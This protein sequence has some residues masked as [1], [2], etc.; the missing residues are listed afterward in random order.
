MQDLTQNRRVRQRRGGLTAGVRGRLASFTLVELLVS[1]TIML[2]LAAIT[3]RLVNTSLDSDRMKTGSRELQSYLAGAR[4]RAI[5]AGQPRGVRFKS[6]ENDPYS[7]RSFVYIGAPTNFSDGQP[8][9]VSTGITAIGP[10]L[11]TIQT[12]YGLANRGVLIPGAQVT[13]GGS[14]VQGGVYYSIAPNS[15]ISTALPWAANSPYTVGQTVQPTAANG[16]TY[17]CTAVTGVAPYNSGATEPTTWPTTQAGQVADN[18]LTWNEFSWELTKPYVAATNSVAYTLQL[19]PAQLP[20]EQP[21]SL[22]RN[23]VIDLRTS[24][25]P[26]SW[27]GPPSAGSTFDVLFSPA[28]TVFGPVASSGRLHF[29]L[30][31]IADTTG[32]VLTSALATPAY[33]RF[34]INAPWLPTTQYVQGNVIVPTPSSYIAFRCLAG[35]TT[36][37]LATQPAWPTQPN[38]TVNDTGGSGTIVW[39]S[40]VKKANLIMSLATSTGRVTTHPVDVSTQLNIQY[41]TPP[42]VVTGYDSFRFAE[43]GEVTQ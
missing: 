1:M 34:Q 41:G 10:S 36:G 3:I 13:L 15:I 35:G 31:D 12:L 14:A 32:E 17:V 2:I 22:P 38:A 18:V 42:V 19:A 6:D 39:Q 8:I 23:I 40:F 4:D 21:R 25:I 26:A 5:Y 9:Y 20:S 27:P 29:V 43:I 16:H 37:A 28:G 7:V 33:N 24:V 11:A 30:A